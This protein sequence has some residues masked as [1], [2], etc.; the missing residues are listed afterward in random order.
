MSH[1]TIVVGTD[2]SESSLKAVERAA[3]LASA[4]SALLIVACAYHPV[5]G[6]EQA[7]ATPE[8]RRYPV[9]PGGRDHWVGNRGINSLSGRLLGSL[10][11]DVAQRAPCDVLIVHT[12]EGGRS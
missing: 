8:P 10:P 12:T 4:S 1:D 2:G 11:A 7:I 6:R 9:P 5:T 3:G